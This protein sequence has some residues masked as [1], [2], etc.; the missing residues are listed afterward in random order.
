M[1]SQLELVDWKLWSFYEKLAK[2]VVIPN[3]S[4]SVGLTTHLAKE[5][6]MDLADKQ[7]IG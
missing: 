3:N 1:Y 7:K 2:W 5:G 6:N 4:L